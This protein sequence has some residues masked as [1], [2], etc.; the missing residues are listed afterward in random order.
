MKITRTI[1]M[2]DVEV[3]IY[4]KTDETV[5]KRDFSLIE[6]TDVEK[7]INKSEAIKYI[8]H[9]IVGQYQNKA[10]IILDEQGMIEDYSLVLDEKAMN[11]N[12]TN[13]ERE[14]E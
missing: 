1:P 3:T 10:T 9:R 8:D 14:E 4:H 7:F 6:G 13:A 5:K 2:M 11:I 12:A